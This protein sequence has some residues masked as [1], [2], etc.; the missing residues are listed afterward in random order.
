MKVLV[1]GATGFTGTWMMDH[2]AGL[3]GVQPTGLAR[4]RPPEHRA[5][6]IPYIIADL[7]DRSAL[8]EKI[9]AICPDAIIHLGGLTR[10]TIGDML[11]V[12]AAG[13]RNI[14]DAGFAANPDCRMLVIS[15]SAVYG[16][17]GTAPIG[18]ATPLRPASDYGISKM[19]Q[20]AVTTMHGAINRTGSCIV[21]P[22]NITGPGQPDAFICGR[23]VRQVVEI[24]KQKR[25]WIDLQEMTSA[26]D[27]LDVR[28]LVK[29][30]WALVSHQEFPQ[31][32]A[33]QIFNMGSGRSCPVAAIIGLIE[34]ITGQH[35][36]VRL[37]E[38]PPPILIPSQQSDNARILSVTGWR[39]AISL[40]ET[41]RDMLAAARKVS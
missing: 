7:L 3:A 4:H 33:G 31:D 39:A 35:Y 41:L 28:D 15:S 30:Y 16:Y 8:V 1:T 26:R 10:G 37:P 29:G 27:F 13:T 18:E 40:K 17:P 32:C 2:L 11:Q 5:G 12:N 20:E 6:K 34:E 36:L 19:A 22:F 24:E 9:S 21:R 25:S 38:Q 23:I 14:L